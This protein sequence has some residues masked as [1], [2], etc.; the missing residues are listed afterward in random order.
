MISRSPVAHVFVREVSTGKYMRWQFYSAISLTPQVQKHPT[1]VGGLDSSLAHGARFRTFTCMRW[2]SCAF[3]L[4]TPRAQNYPTAVVGLVFFVFVLS[5]LRQ[6]LS[7]EVILIPVICFDASA[8]VCCTCAPSRSPCPSP[9]AVCS[10]SPANVSAANL[11][12]PGA[13]GRGRVRLV[14]Q[15]TECSGDGATKQWAG[16]HCYRRERRQERGWSDRRQ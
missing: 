1:G 13:P 14:L 5:K 16:R 8:V 11:L 9:H 2:R 4:L 6:H 3:Y 7:C 10:V 15:A 12:V